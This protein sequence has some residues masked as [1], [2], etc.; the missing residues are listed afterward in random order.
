[1][2]KFV[3]PKYQILGYSQSAVGV[4]H[5]ILCQE[6]VA[7]FYVNVDI[8]ENMETGA[9]KESPSDH[10][11]FHDEYTYENLN[12]ILGVWRPEPKRIIYDFFVDRHGVSRK[13]YV[14]IIHRS[15][16]VARRSTLDWDVRCACDT[17]ELENHGL[18]IGP[19]A[20]IAPHAEIS[21]FVT[22]NRNVSIGHHTRIGEFSTINPGVNIAGHCSIG[23]QV[24]IGIGA[25]IIDG[26]E[27]GDR[28]IVGAGS[29][30]TK[31]LPPDVVAYGVPAKVI[32]NI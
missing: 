22:V 30:V 23:T 3:E 32:R 17:D 8:I 21:N 6:V 7:P 27:I 29:L 14:N 9:K 28:T 11:F 12:A 16:V 10:I 15:V 20:V 31:S 25:N 26:I 18:L 24:S 13:D 5:D 4:I 19:G 2:N 1:M